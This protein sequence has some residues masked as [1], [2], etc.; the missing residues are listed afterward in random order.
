MARLMSQASLVMLLSEYE[1]QGIAALEAM[2]LRRPVLVADTSALRELTVVGGVRTVPLDVSADA[3]ATA[4]VHAMRE[5]QASVP[6]SATLPRWEDSAQRLLRVYS[7]VQ[8]GIG[9]LSSSERR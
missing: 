3:L 9:G 5:G 1:S 6:T 8:T 2:A 7:D 4:M